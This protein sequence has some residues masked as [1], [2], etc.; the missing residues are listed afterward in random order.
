MGLSEF[1]DKLTTVSPL[2]CIGNWKR[3]KMK[4]TPPLPSSVF[5]KFKRIKV[6]SDGN[7]D[8]TQCLI[9]LNS[10]KLSVVFP[11]FTLSAVAG[12]VLQ[13]GR[14]VLHQS[15]WCLCL[16]SVTPPFKLV[17]LSVFFLSTLTL[18]NS[19]TWRCAVLISKSRGSFHSTTTAACFINSEQSTLWCC[20][21]WIWSTWCF[22]YLTLYFRKHKL[23]RLAFWI[24]M[25][26][27]LFIRLCWR[28]HT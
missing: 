14:Q 11:S 3:M 18:A 8:W 20:F 5:I 21:R 26:P 4:R 10:P 27:L 13:N 19:L 16:S 1:L 25:F 28:C 22:I 12:I 7:V 23:L 17:T 15:S 6:V 9:T 24:Q 2:G